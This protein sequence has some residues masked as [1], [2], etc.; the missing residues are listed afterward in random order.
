[1]PQF[2][3]RAT[4]VTR[5]RYQRITGFYDLMERLPEKRFAPWR[6][7]LWRDV[8][9]PRI[10]EIGVGTGKNMPCYPEDARVT[11]IDLTPGM[12][13]RSRR[14]ADNLGIAAD[15]QLG[16]AQNLHFPDGTFDSV[17]A[18]FVFCSVPDPVLGLREI[19]RVLKPGGRLYLL[20]HMR[21]NNPI[22]ASLTDVL[23]P[24]MV[25]MMGAD[26]NRRTL[27]NIRAAGF[28][29]EQTHDL[30]FGGVFKRIAAS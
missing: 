17:V 19:R 11:A 28:T 4:A 22:L 10:L 20:E 15:L 8:Q 21:P 18:T 30:S 24:V 9:G 6:V 14:R 27:D 7:E 3:S 23:N 29:L 12:V 16:D 5:A 25:R 1:M 13:A 26:I 2:D